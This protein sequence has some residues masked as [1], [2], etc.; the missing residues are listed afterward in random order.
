MAAHFRIESA[1]AVDP[2]Q[3][4]PDG[5]AGSLGPSMEGHHM[6]IH[7]W[8][9][10]QL[11]ASLSEAEAQG[12]DPL[13][14]LRALLAVCVELNGSLRDSTELAHELQFLADNLDPLRDYGFIR[15]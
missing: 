7:Q 9:R 1:V 13:L 8:A 14:A 2:D 6:T 5:V 12:R 4:E 3:G 10:E 11:L 15:P